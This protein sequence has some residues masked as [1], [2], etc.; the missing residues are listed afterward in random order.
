[1]QINKNK[2]LWTY[3]ECRIT[4][5]VLNRR[6]VILKKA[7]VPCLRWIQTDVPEYKTGV[8]IRY[9]FQQYVTNRIAEC[10]FRE[11]RKW[12]NLDSVII[13]TPR[14]AIRSG[15]ITINLETTSYFRIFL[16][17]TLARYVEEFPFL[18]DYVFRY[19]SRKT[20]YLS[21][22]ITAHRL[23]YSLTKEQ[24]K[25]QLSCQYDK[26]LVDSGHG[27]FDN[28]T[29]RRADNKFNKFVE[30]RLPFQII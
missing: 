13:E 11:F 20:N 18:I 23:A 6:G 5:A 1:M 24:G 14:Q 25:A 17:L 26:I 4:L 2:C 22:F 29:L 28:Y 10:F 15:Y 7:T 3:R 21:D 27:L 19:S 30:D 8:S 9:Y 12:W 16:A